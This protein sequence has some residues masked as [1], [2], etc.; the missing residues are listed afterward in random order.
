MIFAI[1]SQILFSSQFGDFFVTFLWR[2]VTGIIE[3]GNNITITFYTQ[4]TLSTPIKSKKKQ[5]I[6]LS[7]GQ[8]FTVFSR[9][10]LL[11]PVIL[12]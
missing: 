6:I 8:L 5:K 7:F 4:P 12:S 11:L 3:T 1:A 10:Y 9:K 2:Y